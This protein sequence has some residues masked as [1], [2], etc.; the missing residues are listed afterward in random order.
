MYYRCACCKRAPKHVPMETNQRQNTIQP[1]KKPYRVE[2][3]SEN[4]RNINANNI[5]RGHRSSVAPMAM[6]PPPNNIQH[7]TPT[8]L[9]ASYLFGN[10]AGS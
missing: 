4:E 5:R 8:G 2:Q 6:S 9:S 10:H 3:V 7:D 1:P